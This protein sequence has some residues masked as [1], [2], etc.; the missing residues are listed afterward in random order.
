MRRQNEP[1]RRSINSERRP[2]GNERRPIGSERSPVGNE[3]R[4]IGSERRSVASDRRPVGSDRHTV[5]VERRNESVQNDLINRHRQKTLP[6]L[7]PRQASDVERLMRI[8]RRKVRNRAITMSIGVLFIMLITAVMIIAVMN[9]TKPR[10][11]FMFIQE[12]TVEHKVSSTG[13]IIRD[14][15]VFTAA[16]GG[17]LKPLATEGSRVARGQKVALI[18]PADQQEKIRE[19]AK[20]EQDIVDLQ[21]ELMNSGKGAGAR[22]IY[23]E[24]NAALSSVVNLIRSDLVRSDVSSIG[25]YS[26][27]LEV[28]IDQRSTKLLPIDFRDSRI[29]QLKNTRSQ[30]ELSLGLDSGTIICQQP[31]ILSFELDGLEE[32]IGI[33]SALT[34]TPDDLKEYINHS[35]SSEESD[36]IVEQDDPV[37]RITGSINQV[38]VFWLEDADAANF[39]IDTYQN[40]SIPKDG[41]LIPDCRIIRSQ[42]YENGVLA[43][44]E[45][46]RRIEWFS[47]RRTVDAEI[48]TASTTGMRVPMVS[49]LNYNSNSG[50]AGIMVVNG[51]LTQLVK[52]KVIDHDNEY[53]IIDPVESENYKPE[54]STILVVNPS[55]VEEGQIIAD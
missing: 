20:L 31:G 50:D 49:L 27:S 28:L 18:I 46:S 13:L 14:E 22:A 17:V 40:L 15:S 21:I 10:P 16:A 8:E 12:G 30:L 36:N 3:R 53:A 48:I 1:V 6:R 42:S 7:K 39:E 51:G 54:I 45:T 29:D 4:P 26:T 25:G 32:K 9:Q 2:V 37:L 43:A 35:T 24:T 23:D 38:L 44:F 33:D 47:D 34:I 41:I 55:S 19:L 5:S 52:V 11:R